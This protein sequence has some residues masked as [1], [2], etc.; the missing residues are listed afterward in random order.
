MTRPA[1]VFI[2]YS[3]RNSSFVNELAEVLD[4][5][6]VS[7]FLSRKT[8]RPGEPWITKVGEAL[9]RCDWFLLILSPQAIKST[10]VFREFSYALVDERYEDRLVPCWWRKCELTPRWFSLKSIQNLEVKFPGRKEL[11]FQE[12]I[13]RVWEIAYVSGH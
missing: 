13:E 9:A 1:E 11:A 7:Y 4:R 6:E 10:W 8:L 2:S 3:N 12:L 5:H